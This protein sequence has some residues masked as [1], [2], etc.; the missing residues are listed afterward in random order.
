M[1]DVNLMNITIMIW[2]C[3]WHIFDTPSVFICCNE[4]NISI[5]IRQYITSRYFSKLNCV[6]Q[7]ILRLQKRKKIYTYSAV[8][9]YFLKLQ[10]HDFDICQFKYR[11]VTLYLSLSK[12]NDIK[13]SIM[14]SRAVPPSFHMDLNQTRSTSSKMTLI[15]SCAITQVGSND[16][17]SQDS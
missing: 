12:A 17:L 10:S 5:F 15:K 9:L 13:I 3:L 2:C 1:M 8:K 7:V 14:L 4:N 11:G 6:V 16:I